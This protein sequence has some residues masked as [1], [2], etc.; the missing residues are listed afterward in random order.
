[1]P[2]ARREIPQDP[3][4]Q[5]LAEVSDALDAALEMTFPASDPVAISAT[6]RLAGGGPIRPGR[7][8]RLQTHPPLRR[9]SLETKT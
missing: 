6:E 1:M 3:S 4:T 5:A 2:N 7:L 8:S 9:Q